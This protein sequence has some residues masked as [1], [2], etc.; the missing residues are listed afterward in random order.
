M[1]V[2]AFK[3]LSSFSS[4]EKNDDDMISNRQSGVFWGKLIVMSIKFGLIF[5][6]TV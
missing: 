3:S 4:V 6:T 2:Q 1:K 5:T